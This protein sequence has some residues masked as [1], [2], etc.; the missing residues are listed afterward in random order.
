M[1]LN[2]SLKNLVEKR[3]RALELA[4][5]NLR[6]AE[7]INAIGQLAGGIAHDFNN[8]LTVI[9]G[10]AEL[11][12]AKLEDTKLKN[13]AQQITE[14]AARAA[15]L[16]GQLLAFSRK[17]KYLNV[18]TDIHQ[19]IEEVEKILQHSI[20]KQIIIKHE[21]SASPSRI[22][23]DP[24]QLQNAILNLALNARDAMPVGGE[25]KFVTQNR[26]F[27][28]DDPAED[29]AEGEYIQISVSDTGTGMDKETQQRLFEPF[30]TT[31]EVG[32]GTGLP[33]VFGTVKNHGGT[34]RVYS[35]PGKGSTFKL[36]LPLNFK[37]KKQPKQD[38]SPPAMIKGNS[39]NILVVDDEP[40]ILEV[41]KEMLQE[42]GY[43][44]KICQNPLIAIDIYKN[45][46]Q[47]ID[48]VIL[49]M[50]MPVKN[51][52]VLFK[53][54]KAI[55]PDIKAILASGF[56][57]NGEAQQILDMGVLSFVQKP[58]SKYEIANALARALSNQKNS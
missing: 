46:W 38:V 44:P 32:K 51:G 31:K 18:S 43:Q 35:E 22:Q 11:L 34:I 42:L 24:T 49:D 36:Y 7:K 58:F 28:E 30:F 53:A 10:F 29:L 55:N 15:D 47:K 41:V 3:T 12:T 40:T 9:M 48:L 33:S 23:G 57:I 4:H 6:Q 16:T 1:I 19:L 39:E 8:Q 20:D 17:G 5:E 25:L 27:S 37:Q 54:L 50:V 45:E 26:M 13:Y 21:L 52:K 2:H 14:T 56:T